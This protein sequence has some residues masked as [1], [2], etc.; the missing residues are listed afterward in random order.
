VVT[1]AATPET[2]GFVGQRYDTDAG[3]Q[4]INARYDD[5]QLGLFLQPDWF[6]VTKPGVGTNRFAYAGDDP[7]N[8]SDPGGESGSR[9]G[10]GV[11]AGQ[12]FRTRH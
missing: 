6:D 1:A 11:G 9:T 4:Y 8:A 3:L 5:P 10:G 12:E 7:V 2:K